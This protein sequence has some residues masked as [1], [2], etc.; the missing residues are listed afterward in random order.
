MSGNYVLVTG[1]AGYIGSHVVLALVEAGFVPVV[2]DDLSTGDRSL[3]P[4]GVPFFRLDVGDADAVSAVLRRH[5]CRAVLHFAGSV[6]VPESVARPLRYYCNNTAASRTLIETCLRHGIENLVFSSTAAVYGNPPRV[7]VDEDAPLAP[8]N[9]YGR[10]K[11][12]TEWML[13]DV[14]AAERLRYVA[15]R[16]FNVAGADRSGRTGQV[17][18]KA[19]HLIKVACE[20]VLNKRPPMSVYGTDYD[21]AD[22]TCVRDYIH[23][24]DLA[25]AHV[26]ALGY[27]LAGGSCRVLNCGYGHGHSVREVIGAVGRVAGRPVPAIDAPRRPGD[28]ACLVAGSR[29]I[30]EILGWVPAH[31]HLDTI[32]ADAL[33]WEAGRVAQHQAETGFRSNATG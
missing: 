25:Q 15:L 28:P 19:T 18:P 31:D 26:L 3:V 9:P 14:A 21:T 5:D 12:M 22:G 33:R 20:T 27:L 6:V 7:P 11:L 17:S 29:A 30:R 13:T 4:V 10:S 16:Y 1:G 32:V 8:I 24:S 2:V 23:V